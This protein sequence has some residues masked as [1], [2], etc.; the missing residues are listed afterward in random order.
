[1]GWIY[2]EFLDPTVVNCKKSTVT[3]LWPNPTSRALLGK[4]LHRVLRDPLAKAQS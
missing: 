3:L 1:M 2:L 4:I